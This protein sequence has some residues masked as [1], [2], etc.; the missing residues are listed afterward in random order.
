LSL[1]IIFPLP[2]CYVCKIHLFKGGKTNFLYNGK[3][4]MKKAK[5]L[6]IQIIKGSLI[7]Y[8]IFI[9]ACSVMMT[10]MKAQHSVE[11][12]NNDVRY[13]ILGRVTVEGPDASY[14]ALI[15]QAWNDF[16]AEDVIDIVI[17]KQEKKIFFFTYATT[18]KLSGLAVKYH[19]VQNK[20]VYHG[21][22]S[23]GM[24]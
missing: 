3:P 14:T 9:S 8:S 20:P 1:K 11:P 17:D 23:P 4:G 2:N 21:I 19:E 22:S 5:K 24:R 6:R 15:T 7:F 10:P 16:N 13:E 12:F 18:Y